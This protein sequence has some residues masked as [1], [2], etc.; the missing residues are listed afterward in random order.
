MDLENILVKKRGALR[1]IAGTAAA[2]TGISAFLPGKQASAEDAPKLKQPNFAEWH[3]SSVKNTPGKEFFHPAHP[4]EEIKLSEEQ[5][6]LFQQ[7][8]HDEVF[9]LA[10]SGRYDLRTAKSGFVGA[11][12]M[13]FFVSFDADER[14]WADY[15]KVMGQEYNRFIAQ[16]GTASQGLPSPH[17][18]RLAPATNLARQFPGM[19]PIYIVNSFGNYQIA[20][21]RISQGR[22]WNE[23]SIKRDI[24]DLGASGYTTNWAFK[25]GLISVFQEGNPY[26]FVS[27]GK[28]PEEAINALL[29]ETFHVIVRPFTISHIEKEVNANYLALRDGPLVTIN[30][31][32]EEIS[33]RWTL[34]EEGFV[35]AVIQNYLKEEA[36]RLGLDPQKTVDPFKGLRRYR[37]IKPV[38]KNIQG[39]TPAD[40]YSAYRD[41]PEKLFAD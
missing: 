17:F 28:N 40:A 7:R 3:A 38:R 31:H 10:Q 8:F 1:I 12:E 14:H 26:V 24:P 4:K 23:V 16:F 22:K 11:Q 29:S 39:F 33:G 18:E 25:D 35:H 41:I 30:E 37:L 6:R 34:R 21:F 20:T 2:F 19:I 9:N 36:E 5:F 27:T 15:M 13:P 32:M